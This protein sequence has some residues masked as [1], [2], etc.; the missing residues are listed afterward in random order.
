MNIVYSRSGI[1]DTS[2]TLE[3]DLAPC[4]Y[5]IWTVRAMIDEDGKKRV[6]EWSGNYSK[7]FPPLYLRQTLRFSAS[8]TLLLGSQF[9]NAYPFSTPCEGK[10]KE[11]TVE[12]KNKMMNASPSNPEML[13][14]TSGQSSS[15]PSSPIHSVTKPSTQE[16]I[17]SPSIDGILLGKEIKTTG[18]AGLV[19]GI[20]IKLSLSNNAEKDIAKISGKVKLSD[21]SGNEIG[22][23]TFHAEKRIPSHGNI[24]ITQ[25]VYPIFFLGYIKL[26]EASQEK[27]KAEF[28]FESIEF[29]DGSKGKN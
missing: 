21:G 22:S 23:V 12:I 20:D 13:K 4:F 7:G 16:V 24:E 8:S 2:H 29:S 11:Q 1:T 14:P 27:I 28:T 10:P 19:G 15:G 17:S 18:L 9:N 26:K 6:T 25:T 5:Y 3:D